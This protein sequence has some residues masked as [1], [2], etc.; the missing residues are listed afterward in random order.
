MLTGLIAAAAAVGAVAVGLARHPHPIAPPAAGPPTPAS[1]RGS[2]WDPA[3]PPNAQLAPVGTFL[4]RGKVASAETVFLRDPA[5]C[6][7]A[8]ATDVRPAARPSPPAPP[9]PRR[10]RAHPHTPV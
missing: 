6:D 9:R 7:T 10:G 8:H 1:L 2:A 4:A 5:D 3:A